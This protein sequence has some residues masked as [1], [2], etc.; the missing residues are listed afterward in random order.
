MF[1]NIN[2]KFTYC[3][4]N[5]TAIP[6]II[7]QLTSLSFAKRDCSNKCYSSR[8]RLNVSNNE[9]EITN[10]GQNDSKMYEYQNKCYEV[11]PNRTV[12]SSEDE[13]ICEDLNCA[14]LYNYT[15]KECIEEIPDGYFI[16]NETL[17]TIGKCHFNCKTC[18]GVENYNNENCKT[19]YPGKYLYLRNCVDNCT[20]GFFTDENNIYL[21]FCKC[22]NI[23]CYY[24]SVESMKYNICE[25]CNIEEGYYPKINDL[26]NVESFINC[27][28]DLEG[29]YLDEDEVYKPCYSSCKTCNG[30]GD[31][32]NNNCLKCNYNYT[33][34]ED[35]NDDKNCYKKCEFYYY[36]DSDKK[37]YTII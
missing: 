7:N 4:F 8:K 14:F 25:S 37:Y 9:C 35:F 1:N 6:S 2:H 28:K 34:A 15:Q 24:C 23:K 17:K 21:N 19:C 13:Y 30:F 3:I 11:C 5:K 27:Y 18:Y 22:D 26:S 12:I 32:N 29:Y 31:E 33:F 20:N 16:E 10:C 36:F